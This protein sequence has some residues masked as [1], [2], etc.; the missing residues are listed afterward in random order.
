[1]HSF[2]FRFSH[3]I[4]FFIL[5]PESCYSAINFFEPGMHDNNK[6]ACTLPFLQHFIQS[7]CVS[8]ISAHRADWVYADAALLDVG[9]RKRYD[10]NQTLQLL[11]LSL[12]TTIRSIWESQTKLGK[13][14]GDD[15]KSVFLSMIQSE[16]L[17]GTIRTG[18]IRS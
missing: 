3:Q 17:A 8:H 1:M 6:L 4:I 9:G 14:Y 13:S 12:P 18:F 16:Y 11:Y 2:K 15:L 10:P 7:F 5:S